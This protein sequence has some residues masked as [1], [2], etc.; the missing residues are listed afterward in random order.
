MSHQQDQVLNNWQEQVLITSMGLLAYFNKTIN[1][2]NVII[3]N[4]VR[5][6]K[7]GV[8]QFYCLIN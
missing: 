8:I 6:F 3:T 7:Q 5:V 4:F 2:W 1:I